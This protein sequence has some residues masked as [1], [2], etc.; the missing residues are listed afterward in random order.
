MTPS[1]VPCPTPR[2]AP[3][4][5]TPSPPRLPL[6]PEL[7]RWFGQTG[8]TPT[9]DE[10]SDPEAAQILKQLEDEMEEKKTE[11]QDE[12]EPEAEGTAKSFECQVCG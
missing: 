4:R 8:G 6:L 3:P 12:K 11:P 2:F 7:W 10:E 1:P 9:N 5:L